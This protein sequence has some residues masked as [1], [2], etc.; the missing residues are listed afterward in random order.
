MAP[1]KHP[2]DFC[3]K[4]YASKQGLNNHMA[5]HARSSSSK[6]DEKSNRLKTGEV[7]YTINVKVR[8]H[9]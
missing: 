9:I 8:F 5:T 2:C 1:K 3:D 4:T 7:H 6:V